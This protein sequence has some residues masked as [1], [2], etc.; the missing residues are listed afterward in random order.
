[1][2]EVSDPDFGSGISPGIRM[3]GAGTFLSLESGSR[4]SRVALSMDRTA[5]FR[6]PFRGIRAGLAG[7]AESRM[8][9]PAF[10]C[11]RY[12]SSH[13][14][15]RFCGKRS[16]ASFRSGGALAGREV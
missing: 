4:G 16:E 2:A 14:W 10:S 15:D 3:W 12:F 7:L 11:G 5:V 9:D 8:E 1:M 13:L 6:L